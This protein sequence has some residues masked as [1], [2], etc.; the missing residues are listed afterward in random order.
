MPMFRPG[1]R[2]TFDGR[3]Y[4]ANDPRCPAAA[5]LLTR[6][7]VAQPLGMAPHTYSV[8]TVRP[9][10]DFHARVHKTEQSTP[11][12]VNARTRRGPWANLCYTCWVLE[13]SGA[14]G[15]LGL[16]AGQIILVPLTAAEADLNDGDKPCWGCGCEWA[17]DDDATWLLDHEP[18]CAYLNSMSLPED[19][20]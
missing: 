7:E 10:C 15:S 1:T 18:W 3:V 4:D 8:R 2:A 11:T 6:D 20:S 9:V 17:K 14:W 16:G 13:G 12:I 5:T 19:E